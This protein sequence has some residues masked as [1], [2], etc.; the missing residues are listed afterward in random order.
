MKK[1]SYC[2]KE[3]DSEVS[4]CKECGTVLA[5]ESPVRV[6]EQ[7][8]QLRGKVAAELSGQ[9]KPRNLFIVTTVVAVAG[10]AAAGVFFS[11]SRSL[12]IQL[13]NA[14]RELQQ[15]QARL[16]ELKPLQGYWEGA[17][18]SGADWQSNV[19]ITITG[20][21]LHYRAGK[22]WYETTFTLTTGTNS[23]Q[24]HATIKDGSHRIHI[25]E[26]VP[27]TLKMEDGTLTLGAPDGSFYVLRKVQPQKKNCAPPKTK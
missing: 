16:P 10:I 12:Q 23:Q 26:V 18:W 8:R 20:D 27:T 4:N 3:N 15:A 5:T 13:D 25:G 24:L 14:T 1:C 2:G 21:S 19:S 17:T 7:L 9:K 6:A 11:Q 22:D